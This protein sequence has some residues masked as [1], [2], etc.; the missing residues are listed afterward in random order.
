MQNDPHVLFRHRSKVGHAEQQV[1]L[2]VYHVYLFY[3]HL[4]ALS[5]VQKGEVN[6]SLTQIYCLI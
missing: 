3:F 6:A 1:Y 4:F 5:K 2:L